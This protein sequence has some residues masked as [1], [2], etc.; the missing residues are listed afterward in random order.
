[1][2]RLIA[3]SLGAILGAGFFPPIPAQAVT[4]GEE[5]LFAISADFPAYGTKAEVYLK[6]RNLEN[7]CSSPNAWSTVHLRPD[8]GYTRWVEI[9]WFEDK[10]SNGNKRWRLFYET[11]LGGL[12]E[13]ANILLNCCKWIALRLQNIDG[14]NYWKFYYDS[15][16]N[17]GWTLIGPSGGIDTGFHK[18]YPYSETGRRGDPGT[19]AVDHFRELT[20]KDDRAL[21]NWSHW[22]DAHQF[23]VNYITGYE[24]VDI[25][26]DEY[27]VS[28]V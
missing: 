20:F 19:G 12:K 17:G 18:G 23:G 3:V 8:T 24:Y 6:D 22:T 15:D 14:G 13:Y 25:S 7:S 28:A 2:R 16:A 21:Y 26:H 11:Q 27:Q 1:M 5:T 9:G 4:C 10:D